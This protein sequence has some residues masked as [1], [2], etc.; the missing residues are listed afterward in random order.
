MAETLVLKK[1]ESPT[2]F[3]KEAL[4]GT[5]LAPGLGTIIGAMIGKSRMES[6]ATSGKV[7]TDKPSFWNKDALLGGL[8]GDLVGAGIIIAVV[9]IGAVSSI[10]AGAAPVVLGATAVAAGLGWAASVAAGVY[11]G[12]K[13]GEASQKKE[14]EEAKQQTIVDHI[15]HKVSPEVGKAVEYSMQHNKEWGK[16]VTE[17]RLLADAK[18]HH[19][20][21]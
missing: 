3:N 8:L 18:A 11:L 12:G 1:N 9:G 7:V 17:D 2:Y 4:I 19:H 21:V 5:L 16:Q 10:V 20:H 15:S 6:E 14:F 13:S